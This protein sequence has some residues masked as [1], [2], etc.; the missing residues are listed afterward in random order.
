MNG[1]Q[2]IAA[3][4]FF[5]GAAL[6]FDELKQLFF[7]GFQF[8]GE[9][10]QGI[11][12]DDA[13]ARAGRQIEVTGLDDALQVGAVPGWLREDGEFANVFEDACAQAIES[14]AV[15]GTGLVQV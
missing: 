13:G 4:A 1:A 14:D 8:G 2:D 11:V 3:G 15:G 12:L 6:F 7:N 9:S 5:F 10:R